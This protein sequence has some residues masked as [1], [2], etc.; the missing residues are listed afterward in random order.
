LDCGLHA[1]LFTADIEVGALKVL[2]GGGAMAGVRVLKV[3]HHGALSS[4]DEG[5]IRQVRPEVAVISVGAYNPY[6]HP[7]DDVLAAYERNGVDLYRTDQQGAVWITAKLSS[8]ASQVQTARGNLLQ[9]VW[10]GQSPYA[11]FVAE[12]RNLRRLGGQGEGL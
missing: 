10:F 8:G 3:P 9:P 11:F 4:L 6:G 7:A 5:W 1:I 2:S 12:G